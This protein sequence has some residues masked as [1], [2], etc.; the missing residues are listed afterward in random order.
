MERERERHIMF[1]GSEEKWGE[2]SVRQ[3]PL[4][5]KKNLSKKIKTEL[6]NTN[7]DCREIKIH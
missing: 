2:E 6:Q 3:G 5:P 4:S 7:R 1:S